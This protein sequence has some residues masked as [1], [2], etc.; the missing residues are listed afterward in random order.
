MEASLASTRVH[1]LLLFGDGPFQLPECHLYLSS[2]WT[3]VRPLYSSAAAAKCASPS[4]AQRLAN[5]WKRL[6]FAKESSME[7]GIVH[8]KALGQHMII[9]NDGDAAVKMLNKKSNIYSD[10]PVQMMAGEL[11]GWKN[12]IPLT[13]YGDRLRTY[14][15]MLHRVIGTRNKIL[16]FHDR[17]EVGAYGALRRLLSQKPESLVNTLRKTS[18]S[19]ILNISIGYHVEEDSDPFVHLVDVAVG[20]FSKAIEPGVWLVDI[21]PAIKYI[22]A[23]FPG[24]SFKKV[25]AN[26]AESLMA[27]VTQPYD[28]VKRQ[29]ADN[30]AAPSFMLEHLEG[31]D[32]SPDEED[33]IKW[34]A[35]GLYAGGTDTIASSMC[36]FFL[37]MTLYPEVQKLAQQEIDSVVG[38]DRLPTLDDR[39]PYVEALVSEVLRWAPVAPLGK[40]F[41]I[42]G[43]TKIQKPSI[44]NGLWRQ[45]EVPQSKI[46]DCT[47]LALA[48]VLFRPPSI[49]PGMH[50]VDASL[51]LQCATIL[52]VF[53]ITKAVEN[54]V[55]IEP[56]VEYT[57]GSISHPKPFKCSVKPRSAKAEELIVS[58]QPVDFDDPS[59]CTI[60]KCPSRTPPFDR[61]YVLIA[62][63]PYSPDQSAAPTDILPYGSHPMSAALNASLAPNRGN[64]YPFSSTAFAIALMSSPM[65]HSS[66]IN[67]FGRIGLNVSSGIHARQGKDEN[68]SR[69]HLLSRFQYFSET[70]A[71]RGGDSATWAIPTGPSNTLIYQP[72]ATRKL[73]AP[74]LQSERYSSVL[75]TMDGCL[76]H[77]HVLILNTMIHVKLLDVILLALGSWFVRRIIV[78]R[79]KAPLPPGPKGWP[80]IGNFMS[81]PRNRRWETFA[82][83]EMKWGSI[84]HISAF[85]KHLIVVNNGKTAVEMLNKKSNIYSDRPAF[86]MVGELVGWNNSITLSPYG[87]RL[88]KSRAMVQRVIGSRVDVKE[89]HSYIEAEAYRALRRLL[90]KPEA[91]VETLRKTSGAIILRIS[92]GYCTLEDDDPLVNLAD[93]TI[94][95][96][97]EA[98]EVGKWLVDIIPAMKYIPAWFP[99]AAFKKNAAQWKKN[100]IEM[101]TRPY[102]LVKYRMADNTAL[103][104]FTS[105]LLEGREV[106]PEQEDLIK[107]AAVSLYGGGADTVVSA[108]STFFLAMTLYPEVQQRAQLEIDSV[109][110]N[111]RLPTLDD[112]LP[113]VEAIVSEVLRWGTVVPLGVVHRLMQDDIQDGFLIPQGSTIIPNIWKMLHDP[114]TYTNP[115]TFNPQRFLESDGVPAEQ[116]PRL[117]CFGFGRRICPGMH[118]VNAS[119]PLQ[120]A[121]MLAVFNITKAISENG[122]IVEPIAEFT[123]GVISHPKPFKC[124]VNPRSA[125]AEA[126]IMLSQPA[127]F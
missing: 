73:I 85:G 56:A 40:C 49:C 19:I 113:Y 36:S 22:P 59:M 117:Y 39:L 5:Y 30:T 23:W 95:Q 34:A 27:M 61:E 10:R 107:W 14:R 7:G 115:E 110:G 77:G 65:F 74:I 112:H 69:S 37:A 92:Y 76:R 57:S 71:V 48:D 119:L 78:Q 58:S 66:N 91:L 79:R 104:S 93:V 83:W 101:V 68:L 28:F 90:V 24:A 80:F 96:F 102:D 121:T 1:C 38:N 41:M 89:Y 35:V 50:L 125:N 4:W 114:Q 16:A 18:G 20:D 105:N 81:L 52:A 2:L 17:I 122:I 9:V 54:G 87:D 126:L 42:L 103:P 120:C 46:Q 26:W 106:T 62:S 53:N 33:L 100:V 44:R 84:I 70:L 6:E 43:L 3:L 21:I 60:P 88:R 67:I 111:D 31:R 127:D 118:L 12:S 98:G 51:F 32:V 8:I 123:D 94:T 55:V 72:I 124:S 11:I 63:A 64:M 97:S 86:V 75:A 108:M 29:M 116:D 109:V 15:S 47:A 13:P 45:T 82:E 99:G 25:A